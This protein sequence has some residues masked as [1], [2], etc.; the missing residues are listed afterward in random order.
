MTYGMPTL[1]EFDTLEE[2]AILCHKLGLKFIELNMNLPQYTE[3][4]LKEI[5]FLKALSE[6]YGMFYTIHLDENLNVCDFNSRVGRA[7]E[8]TVYE[9]IEAALTLGAPLIN[10]H[11]HNGIFVTLPDRQVYLYE[12]YK[13]IY[14]EKLIAFRDHCSKLIGN[15]NLLVSME[16]TGGFHPFQKEGIEEMLKS[17]VFSLTWDIG[18]SHAAGGEDEIFILSHKDRLK[19]FHIHDASGKKNHLT[20]GTGDIKLQ[21]KLSLAV[22]TGSRCVLETKTSVSLS[23]SVAWLRERELL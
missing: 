15:N 19:H 16:N 11:M 18:H 20:L 4:K 12:K 5:G 8:E 2:N 17:P 14:L 13:E 6:E 9:I 7:Y 22:E 10:M 3:N 21:E 1:I 23:E